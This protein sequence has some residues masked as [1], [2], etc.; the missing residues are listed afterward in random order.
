MNTQTEMFT[1]S[2]NVMMPV[3]GRITQLTDDRRVELSKFA[4]DCNKNA[5]VD[6]AGN[7]SAEI[8]HYLQG[9]DSLTP[10]G[11]LRLFGCFRLGAR[12]FD[13]KRDGHDIKTEM[14][15]LE[16]GKRVARY[17]LNKERV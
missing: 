9:G 10:I 6:H 15:T 13:L 12:I 2:G 16:S 5:G 17:S 1:Q 7:Q 3:V 4:E 11:A 14:V 8:L